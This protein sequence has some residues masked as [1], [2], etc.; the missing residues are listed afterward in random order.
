MK[1]RNPYQISGYR[2]S[3]VDTETIH[4]IVCRA[5]PP[6]GG[7]TARVKTVTDF[8]SDH[9]YSGRAVTYRCA[10]CG[11]DFMIKNG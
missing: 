8:A 11:R 10:S 4:E 7:R 2:N 3:E 5:K 1:K 9:A 6:C